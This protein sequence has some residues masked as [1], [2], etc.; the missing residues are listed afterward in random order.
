MRVDVASNGPWLAS[1]ASLRSLV[2]LPHGVKVPS[3]V[4]FT[5]GQDG[6]TLQP[7]MWMFLA[8]LV[9]FLT[10]RIVTRLIRSGSGGGAGLG[11]VSIAGNHVHH[12]VFGILVIIGTGIV[13]VSATP[14]GVA[15]D[16]AAAVFGAGVGLTV[17]EFALWLH[18]EDVYWTNEGRKSVDAIFCVLAIT[19]ALI[20]GANFVT[21]H[22]G[23]AAW[24]SSVGAIAVNLLLCV[25]CL[26]KG[27]VVTG[28]VGIA[29]G[30][31]ALIGAI[32]LAKPGSWW[33][34]HRYASRPRRAARAARRYD[35]HYLERWNRLRDLV[36]GAPSR[37]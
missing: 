12:Q 3:G 28:V 10:T 30:V 25:I 5:V 31:V 27:K 34:E 2:D 19:G 1:R 11:N 16:V 7:M 29:V 24:W 15:L 21:G 36:A 33:A 9:T 6:H 14:R 35:Q 26:L 18:L 37:E 8:I 23:T 20:G 17:D 22:L 32:R 4:K 13:L